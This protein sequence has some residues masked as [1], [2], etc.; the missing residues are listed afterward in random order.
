MSKLLKKLKPGVRVI[1]IESG[2]E[3][4]VSYN[5]DIVPDNITVEFEPSVVVSSK[6]LNVAAISYPISDIENRIKL[7]DKYGN[8]KVGDRVRDGHS[9]NKGIIVSTTNGYMHPILVKFTNDETKEYF[10]NGK[11]YPSQN[12]SMLKRLKVKKPK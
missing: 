4:Y 2:V 6:N 3:G 5:R 9:G 11:L 12:V 10:G 7:A 8:Y 1:D